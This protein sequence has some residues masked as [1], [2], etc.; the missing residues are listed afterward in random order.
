MFMQSWVPT[1]GTVLQ[2]TLHLDFETRSLTDLKLTD[3]FRKI[4]E[5]FNT[6]SSVL[7]YECMPPSIFL[8]M[9][10]KG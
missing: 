6:A 1:L 4:Q 7:G 2:G 10:A 3:P 9:G 5:S 8:C